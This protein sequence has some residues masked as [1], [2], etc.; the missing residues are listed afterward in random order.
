V[1]GALDEAYRHLLGLGGIELRRLAEDAEHRDAV[2]ADRGVEI[3]Q[4]VDRLLVDA[5]VVMERRRRDRESACSLGGELCHLCLSLASRRAR[6]RR[7]RDDGYL[8]L[9]ADFLISSS[10]KKISLAWVTI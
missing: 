4:L 1:L 2:A 9:R 5:A 10:E 3:G 6:A 8:N 7:A